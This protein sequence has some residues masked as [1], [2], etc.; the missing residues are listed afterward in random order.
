MRKIDDVKEIQ[1]ILLENLI[2]L[3]K[4]CDKHDLKFFLSNGTL[5]GAV[6]YGAFIPWDDDADVFMPREDYNKLL[7]LENIND[8]FHELMAKEKN[9]IWNMPYAKLRDKRTLLKETSADFGLENGVAIDIFPLDSWYGNQKQAI[10]QAKYCGLL[11]RF[12]SAAVEERFI[13]PKK[14]ISRVI[15]Y[16]I[17]KYSR[18]RGVK[19]FYDKIIKET[20]RG[21]DKKT[22][23]KGS[24]AWSLYG[25]KEVIPADVF[26]ESAE[27]WFCEERFPIPRGYDVYLR[28]LYGDYFKDPPKEKQKTHHDIT[29]WWKDEY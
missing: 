16:C 21:N 17:W 28:S 3:K 14:G 25:K 1:E 7:E 8:E 11:R 18:F 13:S 6:K 24:V 19:V 4:I 9:Q 15:L 23:F 29:V 26:D 5:L 22:L 12:L 20:N 27:V 10:L 2:F